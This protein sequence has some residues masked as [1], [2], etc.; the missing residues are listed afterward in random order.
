MQIEKKL[1]KLRNMF[2]YTFLY[3]LVFSL[4]VHCVTFSITQNTS[5]FFLKC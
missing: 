2:S 4:K 5:M 3:L 1:N